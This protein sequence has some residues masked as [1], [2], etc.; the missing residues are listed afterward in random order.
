MIFNNSRYIFYKQRITLSGCC[1]LLFLSMLSINT[2]AGGMSDPDADTIERALKDAAENCITQETKLS[3]HALMNLTAAK[4]LLANLA[5][6]INGHYP[7]AELDSE[8]P[9]AHHRESV[10]INYPC[11]VLRLF[12]T[13]PLKL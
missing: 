7:A 1:L 4:S 10:R 8:V 11:G 12:P 13:D 3:Q 5:V 6:L 9:E 2:Y